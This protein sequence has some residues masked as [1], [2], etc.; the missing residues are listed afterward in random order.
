MTIKLVSIDQVT[1]QQILMFKEPFLKEK[2]LIHGSSGLTTAKD[3]TKWRRQVIKNKE[4]PPTN[5]V[6]VT[7]FVVLNETNDLIA[8]AS[9]NHTLSAYLQIDGGHIAYSI[10]ME[11]RSRGYAKQVLIQVLTYVRKE[12]LANKVL[13]T[14]NQRNTASRSVIISCGGQLTKE[15]QINQQ[16]IEH[17][18]IEI[19]N[20]S[21]FS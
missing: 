6:K 20:N 14:C 16:C 18:W 21:N 7:Q 12:G 5:H 17:Y 10:G 11:Y 3:I 13:L 2:E 15:V 1:D 19:K 4:N 9:F 8:M